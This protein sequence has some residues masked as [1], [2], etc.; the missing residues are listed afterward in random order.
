MVE[1]RV[2]EVPGNCDFK[3]LALFEIIYR[4]HICTLQV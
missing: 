2:F 4:Q 1:Y 3:L